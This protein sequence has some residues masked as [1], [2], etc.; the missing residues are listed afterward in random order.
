MWLVR[1][2]SFK[3]S[4]GDSILGDG[5]KVL[6]IVYNRKGNCIPLRALNDEL[7]KTGPY[8]CLGRGII[9]IGNIVFN[10]FYFSVI[11]SS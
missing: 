2:G 9:R 3:T 1:I 8:R 11:G 7:K 10:S 6:R 5:Q 4:V